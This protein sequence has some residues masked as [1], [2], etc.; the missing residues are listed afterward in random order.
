MV[1]AS[2]KFDMLINRTNPDVSAIMTKNY[3]DYKQ[4]VYYDDLK[5]KGFMMAF[6]IVNAFDYKDKADPDYVRFEANYMNKTDG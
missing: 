6:G 5:K 4:R 1:Y 2:V 3:Y